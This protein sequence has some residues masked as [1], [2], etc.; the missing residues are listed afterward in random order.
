MKYDLLLPRKILFG[1]ERVREI[2][3]A[4]KPLGLRAVLI[5]GSRTLE[6]KGVVRR[7]IVDL[8]EAGVSILTTETISREPQTDD[9]DRLVDRLRPSLLDGDFV[10]ALGGGSAIDLGKAVAAMLPQSR[11]PDQAGAPVRDYLED[12]GCHR[13]LR[14]DPLPI[15][16]IP[17]TAGTGAEATKNAVIS[18][19][20]PPFKKSLRDDRLM[21]ALVLVDPALTLDCPPG[22]TA[23]SGMDALTQL[24]ESYVSRRRQPLTDAIVEQGLALA[25]EA[26]PELAANPQNLEIRCRMAHAALI[27]GIA[28]ANAGLGLAHG[29]APALGVHGRV[30]HGAACAL[31]L[32]A[33]LRANAPVCPE[34]Y[35][36]LG[37]LLLGLDPK[38][39]DETATALLIDRVEALCDLL[40]LPRRLSDL[41]IDPAA[42][43]VLARDSK[44]ASM[45]GNPRTLT[46]EEVAD[47]LRDIA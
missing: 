28:L 35:G 45:S 34:R 43:S 32:P 26:L 25:M 44:G 14:A 37:R 30:S 46:E 17:T 31:L 2:G 29:V 13:T 9:V 21:P 15:V 38:T 36:R 7:L 41:G 6:K 33:T 22:V 4:A 8:E 3:R 12:V 1:P 18:S 39:P 24:F 11:I 5:V 42:I 19:F 27:S 20:D 23:E 47:I 16:A 40:G 10:I